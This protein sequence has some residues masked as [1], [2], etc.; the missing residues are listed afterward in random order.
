MKKFKFI[1]MLVGLLPLLGYSQTI[2][3]SNKNPFF[4]QKLDTKA[5]CR[6]FRP[7]PNKF[8][9]NRQQNRTDMFN[10]TFGYQ[11]M[12]D[13]IYMKSGKVVIIFNEQKIK[14]FIQTRKRKWMNL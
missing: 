1:L 11:V 4:P 7:I 12:P 6:C 13:S 3:T 14:Q 10:R 5:Q 2:D 9:A 8:E